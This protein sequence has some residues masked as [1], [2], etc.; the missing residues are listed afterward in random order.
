ME[1]GVAYATPFV[2]QIENL[3]L[4][5]GAFDEQG[6]ALDGS[7][8]VSFNYKPLPSAFWPTNGSTDD[9]MV[10]LSA[11]YPDSEQCLHGDRTGPGL[12]SR[13]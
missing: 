8:L 2:F 7:H 6:F 1:M 9:V 12:H 11:A 3:Q 4:G 13:P 10:R 5:A